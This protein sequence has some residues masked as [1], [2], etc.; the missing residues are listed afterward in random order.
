[1]IIINTIYDCNGYDDG[2]HLKHCI[3]EIK[4]QNERDVNQNQI[5]NLLLV[6][7]NI[8]LAALQWKSEWT[9]TRSQ[10]DSNK[11]RNK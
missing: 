9:K 3:P 11:Y 6:H 1:M 4:E 10:T 2:E 8:F 7:A 5:F